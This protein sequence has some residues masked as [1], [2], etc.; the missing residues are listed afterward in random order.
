MKLLWKTVLPILIL[1]IIMTGCGSSADTSSLTLNKKGVLAQT[2]V[3]EWDQEQ[4]D[5]K[6]LQ[7]QIEAD[8]QAYGQNI[9]LDSI[10]TKDALVTVKM[11]YQNIESYAAYNNVTLFQGTVA[12]CQAAGYLLE[13]EFKKADGESVSRTE[14]LNLGEKCTVLVFQ[15]AVTVKVPGKILCCSSSLE[16]LSNKE[17]KASLAEGTTDIVLTDP[18]YV[19][20][21]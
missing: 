2:I 8:I 18:V 14:V 13:G 11:T 12:E 1:S 17:V 4:Y 10:R 5:K 20:Y 7:E 19:I 3:E 21:K 6:E 9:A 16:V 15:E